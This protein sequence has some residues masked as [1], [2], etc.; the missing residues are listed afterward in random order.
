M[1]WNEDGKSRKAKGRDSKWP[2]LED[3]SKA[4]KKGKKRKK[5]TSEQ[6]MNLPHSAWLECTPPPRAVIIL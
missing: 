2:V 1:D 6:E 4:R 5:T 3:N